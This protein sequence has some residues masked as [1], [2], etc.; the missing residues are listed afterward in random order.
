MQD[1]CVLQRLFSMFSSSMLLK[2]LS[3]ILALYLSRTAKSLCWLGLCPVIPARELF[4]PSK[5]QFVS[6]C[7][8][9][10]A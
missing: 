9:D 1:T 5:K 6:Y 2:L 3:A 10:L 4:K 8:F 7:I